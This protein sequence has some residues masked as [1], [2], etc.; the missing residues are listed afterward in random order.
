MIE[1]ISLDNSR[2]FSL[3]IGKRVL[4]SQVFKTSGVIPVYSANVYQPFGYIEKSNISDF[5][6]N[7]VLWGIDGNFEFNVIRK[8]TKFA[9]TDHCGT[10]KILDDRIL[11]DYLQYQMELK[12][13]ILG[14]DRNLRPSLKVMSQVLVQIP[15]KSN[16][17]PD[18]KEQQK[19]VKKYTKLRTIKD[20]LKMRSEEFNSIDIEFELPKPYIK[21]KVGEIFDLKIPSN[22]SWF[23]Q[24][25]V[26]KNKGN[27]PVYS[28][29]QVP[30]NIS[31]GFI[32]DNLPDVQ[33]F[34]DILTWNID[35]SVGKAFF[36]KGRFSLSEKVIPLVLQK[37]WNGK[38]ELQY[39]KSILEVKAIEEG[40]SYTN[41]AGKGR[42]K[43][44][45][46]EIPSKIDESKDEPDFKQQQE[47]AHKYE[48]LYALSSQMSQSLEELYKIV[49][50]IE[51]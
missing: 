3:S 46:I 32:K 16:D 10:V 14:Y 27:V 36:R 40:L 35:G 11:P 19:I 2:F 18:V 49:I 37:R 28:A 45:E 13:R 5:D 8:G 22:R 42:I 38:I 39:V 51:K 48:K 7:Y 12:S 9:F 20:D 41:K 6:H 31:Y 30:N 47:I 26:N 17:V 43:D 25:F 21:L 1:S 24:E 50:S 34:E 15:F 33:Y 23:T 4:K 44:I 29:S